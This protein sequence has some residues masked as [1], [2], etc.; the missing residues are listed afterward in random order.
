MKKFAANYVVSEVGV[1]LKNGVVIAGEDGFAVGY[2]NTNGDLQ[3]TE[4]LI[5][6]NG[7][8]MAGYSYSKTNAAIAFPGNNNSFDLFV[9]QSVAALTQFSI[10]EMIELGKQIQIQFPEMKIDFILN[11]ISQILQAKGGFI[12]ENIPGIYLLTG[13]NLLELRFKAN[14][15]LKK[16]L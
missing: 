9:L 10:Q 15:R 7:I 16:I 5:F 4:Q 8:L 11:E 2:I 12:K 1:F 13:A 6:Y 3:E 14:S